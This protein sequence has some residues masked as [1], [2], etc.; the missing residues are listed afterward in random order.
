MLQKLIKFYNKY[1]NR[2]G[3]AQQV[4]GDGKNGG[5]GANGESLG[6]DGLQNGESKRKGASKDKKKKKNAAQ[7]SVN[8]GN[9]SQL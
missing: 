2:G 4:S 5:I 9:S 7:T 6:A 1:Y 8:Q 3:N